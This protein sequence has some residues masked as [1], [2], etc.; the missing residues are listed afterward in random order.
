V[1]TGSGWVVF[2][3]R[4]DPLQIDDAAGSTGEDGPEMGEVCEQEHCWSGG[5]A[6]RHCRRSRRPEMDEETAAERGGEVAATVVLLLHVGWG[7][8]AISASPSDGVTAHQLAGEVRDQ[9]EGVVCSQGVVSDQ[10]EGVVWD[11]PDDV[12]SIHVAE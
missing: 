7:H 3:V 6:F 4:R 8:L 2:S 12:D 10:A 5:T 1:E 11:Q 9:S